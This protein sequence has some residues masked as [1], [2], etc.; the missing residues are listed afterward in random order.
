[1][2]QIPK[3]QHHAF[4]PAFHAQFRISGFLRISDFELR[5]WGGHPALDTL[6]PSPYP[7]FMVGVVIQ[8]AEVV[9]PVP[10]KTTWVTLGT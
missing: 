10:T 4:S 3:I 6:C 2:I 9:M 8:R 1:M 7:R 5:I